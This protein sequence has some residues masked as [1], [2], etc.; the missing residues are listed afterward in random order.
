MKGLTMKEDDCQECV[1]N[2]L[3][4]PYEKEICEETDCI[5]EGDENLSQSYQWLEFSY[6]KYCDNLWNYKLNLKD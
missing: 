4:T 2:G 1:F 3:C 6:N 5:S